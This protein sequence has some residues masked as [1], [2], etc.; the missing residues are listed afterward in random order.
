MTQQ[1]SPSWGCFP[2]LP[3]HG[4]LTSGLAT[5][6]GG[7]RP[8]VARGRG[9]SP[10]G[11][12]EL[13][14]CLSIGPPRQGA[15]L[16]FHLSSSGSSELGK[17]PGL[18]AGE[19]EWTAGTVFHSVTVLSGWAPSARSMKECGRRSLAMGRAGKRTSAERSTVDRSLILRFP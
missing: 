3:A 6:G 1:N 19:R 2:V 7:P 5:L 18:V 13:K 12:A 4:L 15:A 10:G 8:A 11:P 17:G 9:D 16:D 14:G